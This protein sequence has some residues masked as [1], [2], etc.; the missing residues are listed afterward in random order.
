[1]RTRLHSYI[2]VLQL[3]FGGGPIHKLQHGAQI[4]DVDAS[5][6]Q[7]LGQGGSIHGQGAVVQAVLDLLK[8]AVHGDEIERLK[9]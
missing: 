8:H 6:V 9:D 5:L 1:M 7:G 3:C 2:E 4:T